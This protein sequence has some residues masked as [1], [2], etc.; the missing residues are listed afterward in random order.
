MR[1]APD[2]AALRE[3]LQLIVG[4]RAEAGRNDRVGAR[5]ERQEARRIMSRDDWYD[6]VTQS[7]GY[8]LEARE[9]AGIFQ[10]IVIPDLGKAPDVAERIDGWAGGAGPEMICGLLIAARDAGL[11]ERT[12]LL[13]RKNKKDPVQQV[14]QIMLPR[15]ASRWTEEKGIAEWWDIDQL[16]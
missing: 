13:A 5:V 14:R 10:I 8:Q 16:P 9:L 11:K 3:I 4:S 12:G 6:S 1:E 15:L 7:S 2:P